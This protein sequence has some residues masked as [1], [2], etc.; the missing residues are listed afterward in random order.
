M[1]FVND[2]LTTDEQRISGED[3]LVVAILKQIADAIL[4][5]ARRVQR[6]HLDSLA[7]GE[8]LA[9]AGSL[10]DL[11]TILATNDRNVVR[12]QSLGV[13][14]SM[15][16]VAGSGQQGVVVRDRAERTDGC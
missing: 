7:N 9:V 10:C 3:R 4:R 5:M 14:A 2:Y 12:L 6:L 13:T 16:M 8:C 11:V 15:V 1:P